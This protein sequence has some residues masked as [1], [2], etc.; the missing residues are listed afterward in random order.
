[1]VLGGGFGG[2]AA[3]CALEGRLGSRHE[4]TL[5]DRNRTTHLCG[6]NP[7]LIVGEREQDWRHF[8]I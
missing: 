3:A 4:V 8:R 7:M 1:M 5:I 6:M 2:V